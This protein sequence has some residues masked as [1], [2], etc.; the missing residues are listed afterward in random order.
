[1][2]KIELSNALNG[3]IK[4][5]TD[6]Q[7]NSADQSVDIIKVYEIED[8]SSPESLLKAVDFLYDISEDL[9]LSLGSDFDPLQIQ[10]DIDWGEKY[11]PSIEEINCRIKDLQEEI[12]SLKELKR[13][14]T[15]K[16]ANNV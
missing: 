11:T 7:Y 10:I 16:D 1:M 6:T 12:K 5:I 15:E 4:K 2:I 13:S 14:L 8:Q 9:G 3:V